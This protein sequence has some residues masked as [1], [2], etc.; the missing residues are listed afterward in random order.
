M[1]SMSGC[2]SAWTA[3]RATSGTRT[4]L[5][6]AT[7]KAGWTG[8]DR[9][10]TTQGVGPPAPRPG[11]AD[12]ATAAGV[13]HRRGSV[14]PAPVALARLVAIVLVAGG[15]LG[16]RLL[17]LSRWRVGRRL[18]G[19][20]RLAHGQ[21]A[22]PGQPGA[23]PTRLRRR[24]G[25]SCPAS[26]SLEVPASAL[27]AELRR[28]PPLPPVA[29]HA[30]T[31][32]PSPPRSARAPSSV[33]PCSRRRLIRHLPPSRDDAHALA[34]LRVVGDEREVPAELD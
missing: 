24:A 11:A 3:S 8:R 33:R 27:K 20:L 18:H 9:R 34:G 30:R 7:S 21:L 2:W 16:E 10:R 32:E 31:G 15:R 4:A 6:C 26:A 1:S 22:S 25:P 17:D 29:P 23:E 5:G 19:L 14:V 28:L 12:G 13:P